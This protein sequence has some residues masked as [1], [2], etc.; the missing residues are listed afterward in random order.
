MNEDTIEIILEH[1][2]ANEQEY[3]AMGKVD[4]TDPDD[5]E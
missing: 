4:K 3:I 1:I 5:Q 2:R